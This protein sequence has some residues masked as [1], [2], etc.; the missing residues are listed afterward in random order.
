MCSLKNK[1]QNK[2]FIFIREQSKHVLLI[3]NQYCDIYNGTCILK[4]LELSYQL[5]SSSGS[6]SYVL[7]KNSVIMG[8]IVYVNSFSFK[9]SEYINSPSLNAH[10]E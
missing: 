5:R 6:T 9:P 4:D 3:D 10:V 2:A 8:I 7:N 1:D